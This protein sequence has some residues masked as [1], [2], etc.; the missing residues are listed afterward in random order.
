MSLGLDSPATAVPESPAE[1]LPA[2]LPAR[3]GVGLAGLWARVGLAMALLAASA[4]GRAWQARR[5]DQRL[6]DGR[7]APFAVADLPKT[8]GPWVGSDITMD[9]T[10]AR[11]TGSTEQIQRLY[12]NSITG[13]KVEMV[14]LFGPST[15]MFIHAPDVCY[16]AAGYERVA[17][18]LPHQIAAPGDASRWLFQELIFNKGEGGAA[19]QQEVYFSWRYAGAWNPGMITR[20]VSERIPGMFKVQVARPIRDRELEVRSIGNPCEAFL[21]CLM[22]EIDRRIAQGQAAHGQK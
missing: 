12:Q 4:A 20:K 1:D 22:P 16:P 11:A 3:P 15:E 8:L 18:P 7:I 5:V 2:P 6:R 19:D 10:I 21:A 14:F 9:P 13:Q 17:G